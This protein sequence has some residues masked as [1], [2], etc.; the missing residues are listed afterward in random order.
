MPLLIYDKTIFGSRPWTRWCCRWDLMVDCMGLTE[1]NCHGCRRDLIVHF[2]VCIQ[3]NSDGVFGISPNIHIPSST[4]AAGYRERRI[5]DPSL[6][7]PQLRPTVMKAPSIVTA[8]NCVFLMVPSWSIQLHFVFA[9]IFGHSQ[10]VTW[11]VNQTFDESRFTLMWT[12][13]LTGR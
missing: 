9:L 11:T 3:M 4:L 6:P 5:K 1:M 7:L 12:S 2:F 10:P 8:R 13:W